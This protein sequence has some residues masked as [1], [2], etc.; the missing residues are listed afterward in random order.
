MSIFAQIFCMK[1]QLLSLLH[2]RTP[3][4]WTCRGCN[5]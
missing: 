5:M 1:L 4:G 2:F 3:K